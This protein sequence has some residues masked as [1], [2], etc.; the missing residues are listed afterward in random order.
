M[1]TVFLNHFEELMV[2]A[3]IDMDPDDYRACMV[4]RFLHNRS[5]LVGRGGRERPWPCDPDPAARVRRLR[6]RVDALS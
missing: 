1:D 6:H 4:Q 5:Y 2:V 3:V